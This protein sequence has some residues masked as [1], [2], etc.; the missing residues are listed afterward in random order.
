MLATVGATTD[1][2]HPNQAGRDLILARPLRGVSTAERL[3]LACIVAFSGGKVRA[4]RE[5]TLAALDEKTRG[6]V[7]A[8]AALVRPAERWISRGR[9]R[10]RSRVRR[11][12]TAT[13]A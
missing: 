3:T 10:A 1:P 5:P 4:D 9:K 8:L 11:L 2:A 7:V 13:P 12:Q 6:Q